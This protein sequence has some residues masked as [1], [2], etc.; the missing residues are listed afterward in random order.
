MLYNFGCL[1]IFSRQPFFLRMMKNNILYIFLIILSGCACPTDIDDDGKV[2]KPSVYCNVSFISAAPDN[3][4]LSVETEFR[5][6]T[7]G[8]SYSSDVFPYII[9]E[10]GQTTLKI[11]DDNDVLLYQNKMRLLEKN[12]YSMF[13]HGFNSNLFVTIANDHIETMNMD[14]SYYRVINLSEDS[15]ELLIRVIGDGLENYQLGYTKSSGIIETRGRLYDIEIIDP[16]NESVLD[17]INDF[18]LKKGYFYNI[19]IRGYYSV[20]HHMR[21]KCK[22]VG[23]KIY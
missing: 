9:T 19:M 17:T 18:E 14:F 13:I 7:D 20:F 11:F 22:V 12:Y 2:V 16:G 8:L 5:D 23:N 21:L 15:P 10:A 1:V 6:I 3:R 4:S